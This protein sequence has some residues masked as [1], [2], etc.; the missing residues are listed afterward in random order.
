[1][2]QR[3]NIMV[4]THTWRRLRSHAKQ[5]GRSASDLVREAVEEKYFPVPSLAQRQKAVKAIV[6]NRKKVKGKIHI[7]S[8]IEKGRL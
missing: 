3:V 2:L 8:L 6:N 5:A 7:K 4:P 1:M